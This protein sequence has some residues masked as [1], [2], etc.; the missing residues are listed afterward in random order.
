M[1]NLALLGGEP[2]SPATR[3]A[4]EAVW[5]PQNETTAKRLNDVYF[6]KGW[7]F[8]SPVI[9]DFA[10]AFAAYHGVKHGIFMANGTVTLQVALAAC[11]IGPGDEVIVPAHT[12][13]S[14]AL[15]VQYLGAT[16]V[17]VDIEHDT[18]CLDV[19]K[20]AAAITAK[21]RAIIPVHLHGS[22]TDMDKVNA[23]AEQHDL[24]VIE[25]C[26]QAHGG[27]WQGKLLGSL[28]DVGSYS[29]QTSKLMASGEGG[30]CI[31]DDDD[32]ADRLFRISH[33][34]YTPG[35][36]QGQASSPPETGMLCHNFRGTGFQ[37]CVLQEQLNGLDAL[38]D[39]YEA[40]RN[41][42]ET[43]LQASTKIRFQQRGRCVTRS[44][45]YKW[46]LIFDAPEY[47]D[48]SIETIT[49]ALNTEGLPVVPAVPPV[50]QHV[51]FNLRADQ[52]RISD[53]GCDQAEAVVE[54][55]VS[56]LHYFLGVEQ[57]SLE[58]I[59]EIIEKV[60]GNLGELRD[61]KK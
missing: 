38:I 46:V 48:V 25:D 1:S 19:D 59:A 29:F 43:R 37:A 61:I 17:F 10:Q 31:T 2:V 34:G 12:W 42:L 40:A 6:S 8:G 4:E 15:A 45:T 26:A 51:L 49:Q 24:K 30:I 35:A 47:R 3:L 28:S 14:T 33:I 44:A 55:S 11:G 18:L 52:Y 5:P 58:T 7:G 41:Y 20:A 39:R 50:Y 21:T 23:L 57:S 54:H 36:L 53:E 9:D 27:Q 56:L 13:V 22:M 16:P 60:M 32:L